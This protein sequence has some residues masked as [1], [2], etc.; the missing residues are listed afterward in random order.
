MSEA[1]YLDNMCVQIVDIYCKG[2]GMIR[3]FSPEELEE[4]FQEGESR[5]ESESPS[6]QE[7]RVG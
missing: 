5:G 4:I 2:V 6:R 1:K 7:H 3:S